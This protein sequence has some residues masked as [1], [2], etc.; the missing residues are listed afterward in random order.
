[1]NKPDSLRAALVAANPDFAIDAD[2]L[3]V[4]IDDGRV[5]ARRTR[6][7]GFEYR[8]QLQ[9][10]AEACTSGP[11]ALMVPIL[12]WLRE[13]QPDLLLR[14]Q[15]DEGAIRFA[16][17]ILDDSSWTI[18]IVLELSEAVTVTARADGSG[19]DVAHLPEPSPDDPLLAGARQDVPLAELAAGGRRVLP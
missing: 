13:H 1:M 17:D 15:K 11:D 2:R 6:A 8:Y 18:A 16:A 5:V 19:W 7:L 14:F 9:I 10:L 3:K 12:L 4:W